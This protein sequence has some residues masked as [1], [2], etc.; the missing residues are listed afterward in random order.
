M[1]RFVLLLGTLAAIAGQAKANTVTLNFDA[2]PTGLLNPF[3]QDGYS[4]TWHG[5]PN[6]YYALARIIREEVSLLN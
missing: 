1:R 5:Y 4:I 2:L 6:K 3:T